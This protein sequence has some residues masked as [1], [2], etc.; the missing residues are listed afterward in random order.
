MD[1]DDLP[2][3]IHAAYR[4]IHDHALHQVIDGMATCY[5]HRAAALAVNAAAPV[6]LHAT[7]DRHAA[8][9]VQAAELRDLL[10]QSISAPDYD[11]DGKCNY[12]RMD[13]A[14]LSRH[15][16]CWQCGLIG[17]VHLADCRIGAALQTDGPDRGHTIL[18]EV[19]RLREANDGLY[20]QA[21]AKELRALQEFRRTVFAA[22]P[23]IWPKDDPHA[24]TFRKIAEAHNALD[25]AA[26]READGG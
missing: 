2:Q 17:G 25:P 10:E 11:S 3:A 15:G 26:Q 4:A 13:V 21:M 18:Q 22:L 6:L 14:R 12:C 7:R 8:L 24:D 19:Q 1:A 9:E 20:R 5:C 23:V 16:H